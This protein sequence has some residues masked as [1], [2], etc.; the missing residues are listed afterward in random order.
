[1]P[2]RIRPRTFLVSRNT[3]RQAVTP[4]CASQTQPANAGNRR[5]LR[6]A[7]NA[8][9]LLKQQ[10]QQSLSESKKRKAPLAKPFQSKKMKL[11][12]QSRLRLQRDNS[13]SQHVRSASVSSVEGAGWHT[14]GLIPSPPGSVITEDGWE[15]AQSR[16]SSPNP[17]AQQS[18]KKVDKFAP[19]SL[20]ETGKIVDALAQGKST[21][22]LSSY[23]VRRIKRLRKF[24]PD[25]A[26]RA[27]NTVPTP[28]HIREALEAL[29]DKEA[30]EVFENSSLTLRELER[31]KKD[32]N[33]KIERKKVAARREQHGSSAPRKSSVPIR[34]KK[35]ATGVQEKSLKP[36]LT[37][38]VSPVSET[39]SNSEPREKTNTK[40]LCD[41]LI[42]DRVQQFMMTARQTRNQT[43]K[44]FRLPY[45]DM[46]KEIN[47]ATVMG[48]RLTKESIYKQALEMRK[49]VIKAIG[50]KGIPEILP[51]EE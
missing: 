40:G 12:P 51:P 15:T 10:S 27:G 9:I 24:F 25:D 26:I 7:P 2:N 11:T 49:A 48:T 30:R 18:V 34:P 39:T 21:E 8:D 22:G 33:A 41:R 47:D 29:K 50:S 19:V 5:I 1:M 16:F 35:R 17:F 13:E 31:L 32:P 6:S 4:Q 3:R 38:D 44:S 23:A 43:S 20:E 37:K 36:K 42:S 28:E 45:D 46:L 14:P